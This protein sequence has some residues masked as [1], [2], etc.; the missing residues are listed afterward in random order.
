MNG[1]AHGPKGSKLNADPL[2]QGVNIACR[3]T[4][5]LAARGVMM[6]TGL[7]LGVLVMAAFFAFTARRALAGTPDLI[8]RRWS[9]ARG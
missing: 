1:E 3:F 6:T 4:V 2:S 8:S 7:P 5:P 9:L